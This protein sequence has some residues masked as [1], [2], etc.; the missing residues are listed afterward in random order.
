MLTK[1]DENEIGNSGVDTSQL[2]WDS[3][4]WPPSYP[5]VLQ[6]CPTINFNGITPT[7]LDQG[8]GNN[9]NLGRSSATPPVLSPPATPVHKIKQSKQFYKSCP[10][11]DICSMMIL[12]CFFFF[13]SL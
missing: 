9:I 1:Q 6:D 5:S 11:R 4:N 8:V 13:L 7:N 3:W 10:V 12:Q 2:H